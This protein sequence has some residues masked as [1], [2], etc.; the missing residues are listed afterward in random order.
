[1]FLSDYIGICFSRTLHYQF[2][3]W[4][5][6]TLPLLAWMADDMPMAMRVVLIGMIEYA[7]NVFPA[8]AFSSYVLQSAHFVLLAWMWM[9]K[10]PILVDRAAPT[11]VD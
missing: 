2:Y 9:A 8:T 11:K 6:H 3:S 10:V 4:Y 1:M 5:F 7:F